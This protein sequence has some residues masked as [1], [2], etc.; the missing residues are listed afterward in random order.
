M[1]P[2]FLAVICGCNAGLPREALH[3]VY[4]PRIQRGDA[5]FAA[6]I[7]GARGALVSVLAHFFEDGRWGAL[8]QS[9]VEG[10]RLSEEDQLFILMQAGLYLTATQGLGASEAQICYERAEVLCLSLGQ[11]R[12]LH[13][14]LM[15][16]WRHA[17]VTDKLTTTM[18]IAQRVY[19]LA[20]RQNDP[21]L[22]LGACRAMAGPLYFMGDFDGARRHAM[23]GVQLW[24][25]GDVPR[26][27]EEVH[28]PAVIC[29]CYGAVS[30]WHL[31]AIASC[32]AAMDEAISLAK[33]LNDTHSLIT[34][35]Y[36]AAGL[37]QFHEHNPAEVERLASYI[38]ELSTREHFAFWLPGAHIFR[39]WA[40]SIF[41]M[42][43]E[44]LVWIE[45]GIR[46][47]RATG[48]TLNMPYLLA[49]KAEALHLADRTSEA[50]DA[51]EEAET[52]AE[53]FEER[54][55]CA[56]LHRLRG[57]FLAAMRAEE[58]QVEA[59]FC[60]AICVAKQQNS[61]SLVARADTDLTRYRT[62]K[63]TR[64]ELTRDAG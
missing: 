56:E 11:P 59:A 33:A 9:T 7:L 39:G 40:R 47:Y 24:R 53:R 2:L 43:A 64:L 5:S 37:K 50:L 6:N 49:L 45:D 3:E 42:P 41:G 1:E 62:R 26:L 15:G 25:V 54:W 8:V 48:A 27:T 13:S 38:I 63:Q 58:V 28:S 36:F 61:I 21:A 12:L 4:L 20:Q 55:W 52:F 19:S 18:R 17:L 51:I 23:H 57:A 30:D 16:H 60:E 31:G 46:E 35:L 10:Q 22:M 14:A 34:A 32:H 29:L 44:G